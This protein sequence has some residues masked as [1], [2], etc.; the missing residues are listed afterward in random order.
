MQQIRSTQEGGLR[1]WN[2]YPCIDPEEY[3][4]AV[5]C[6]LE[7]LAHATPIQMLLS[8]KADIG[9]SLNYNSVGLQH[10]ECCS[11]IREGESAPDEMECGEM[12]IHDKFLLLRTTYLIRLWQHD[13]YE[14]HLFK[15]LR[16]FLSHQ[17]RWWNFCDIESEGMVQL[18]KHLFAKARQFSSQTA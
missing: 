3:N 13:T 9:D 8:S 17:Q 10:L 7:G 11:Y 6:L 15:K 16:T 2:S 12:F 1:W 4:V 14:E 18:R 5:H